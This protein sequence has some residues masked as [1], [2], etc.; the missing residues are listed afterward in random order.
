M[1]ITKKTWKKTP[2]NLKPHNA[3]TKPKKAR[4]IEQSLPKRNGRNKKRFVGILSG[5]YNEIIPC[6]ER[7][8]KKNHTHTHTN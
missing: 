7:L 1:N 2:Y 6:N 5:L 8:M 3:V 4:K